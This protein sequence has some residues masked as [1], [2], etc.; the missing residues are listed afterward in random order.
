MDGLDCIPH[1]L[2]E[3]ALVADGERGAL[4]DPQ[5]CVAWMCAPRWHDDAVFGAL[6]GGGGQYQVVPADPWHVWG[7]YYAPGTLIWHSRWSTSDTVVECREALALPADP[8]RAV[9]LRRVLAGDDPVEL[10]VRCKPAADFGRADVREVERHGDVRTM[11][12]GPLWIRW[13][14]AVDGRVRVDAGQH[15]DFVLEISDRPFDGPPPDPRLCWQETEQGWRE[16][17]PD[18]VDML[19]PH[20]SRHAYSVLNGLTSADGGM[21]AATTSLPERAKLGSDYDYRYAWVRDQCYVGEAVAAHQPHHLMDNTVR[22][23]AERLIEDGPDLRPAYT[24]TGDQIPDQRELDLP[25]YP[26]GT[27]RV[28]NRVRH[29]FQLDVFGE[30]LLLF[31]AAAEHDHLTAEAERAIGI[32]IDA[33]EQQW[34]KTEDGVW[35]L[36]DR[37]WTHSNLTCVAGLRRTAGF[38][39]TNRCTTLADGI[40]AET[41]R[42]SLHPRGHWQRSLDDDSVDA[43]LL[44]PALRGA[45]PADDPRS[46][47][48]VR[49]V[50]EDLGRDGYV[51]RFRHDDRDLGAAEGAFLVCGFWLALA[52][53]QH[54]DAVTAARRFER[55]RASCGPPGLFTEEYDVRQRQ[56]RG[57]IPQ[58]FVHGM[59][60]ECSARLARDW[61]A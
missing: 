35:E 12:S 32:A 7:G 5:G 55:N 58:A 16:R 21:A 56:L 33:I 41:S 1:V 53:H 20:D 47:A 34:R 26:G 31:G 15:H 2:R 29:Q 57:N 46:I 30:A 49:A 4:I 38:M 45:L 3:Y 28:G 24:V 18:C 8:H 48:T 40:L 19:V 14:G 60:L 52:E 17:V 51:Y 43:A 23:V 37:S 61:S 27:D 9:L 44:L 36:D 13:S 11:R 22:F 50:R 6:V 42:T 25:G 54:G 39:M 59:L 10:L